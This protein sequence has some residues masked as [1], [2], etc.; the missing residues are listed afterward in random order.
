MVHTQPAEELVMACTDYSRLAN[1]S[2]IM[3]ED[4]KPFFWTSSR[5]VGASSVLGNDE[6]RTGDGTDV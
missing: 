5:A 4:W 3:V 2:L 6:K 1:N